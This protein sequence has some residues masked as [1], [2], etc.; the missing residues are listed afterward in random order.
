MTMSVPP[1]L[2]SNPGDSEMRAARAAGWSAWDLRW[3]RLQEAGNTSHGAGDFAGAARSWRRAGW[4]AWLFFAPTDPRRATS[5][6]NLALLDRL[7]GRAGRAQKR[8]AKAR[9]LWLGADDFIAAM[10]ITRRARSSLFHLRMETK[11]WDTY[12]DNMQKRLRAFAAE[13]GEALE[14]LEQ[15]KPV[16]CRLFERWRGEK[17]PV[18]DDMRKFLAAAL[19]VGDGAQIKGKQNAQPPA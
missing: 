5:L 18:F 4:I 9:R 3:E 15:G 2:A 14:A 17:P 8:Y 11:H 1:I 13:T 16:S 10:S 19:L 6:A 12:Q 7:A